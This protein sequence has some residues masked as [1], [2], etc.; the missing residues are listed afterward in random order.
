M[1]S[2]SEAK[3][4]PNPSPLT[5][6]TSP[7]IS[8]SS[9][10]APR[11]GPIILSTWRFGEKA[12]AAGWPYLV[13]GARSSLDAVEQ[14]CRA[15]EA[16]PE[17]MTVGRGGYPDRSGEVTLDASIML[18]PARCGA[19]C[20]VRRFMHPVS[21]ARLVME[22]CPHVMLAGEG[23]ERFAERHGMEPSNLDTE[24]SRAAWEKWIDEQP[25]AGHE[26]RHGDP[27]EAN[28]VEEVD[29]QRADESLPH[30]RS[31][32]TVGILAR[33]AAG[34]IAGA[35][36]TS[37]LRFKL[38]GRVGDSPIIGHGLYVD[39]DHGAAVATGWG[40]LIMGV[41]GSFLAVELMRRG[42]TPRDA[43]VEVLQRIV[44]S[45]EIRE[46]HQAA[47]VA[48][49]TSG[50]W[51]SAALRPGYRTAVRTPTRVEL[52]DPDRVMLP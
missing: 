5:P 33:D 51:S 41:C 15:V 12:N 7:L 27:P 9:P 8:R 44:D 35:C 32:D 39:P 10:L 6:H 17:I 19:A 26:K 18:S 20:C 1:E 14:A 42:A 38:P 31:H 23:A 45:Y 29:G 24:Q 22:K 43:A 13:S 11:S 21:I 46:E 40:E 2:D 48:L 3:R 30:N 25:E 4:V 52:V 47:I 36:S 34:Q 28:T 50:Q 49:G 16:D 37:G